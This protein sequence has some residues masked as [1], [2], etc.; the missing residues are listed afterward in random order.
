MFKFTMNN[1]S[2]LPL[3]C[4]SIFYILRL[5]NENT[6]LFIIYVWLNTLYHF[7]ISENIEKN[8]QVLNIR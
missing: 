2:V 6:I 7:T 3:L 5:V 4:V 1:S 8:Q